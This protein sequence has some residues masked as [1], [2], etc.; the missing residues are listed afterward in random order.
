MTQEALEAEPTT[1]TP[2]QP[3]TGRK[4][5]QAPDVFAP[6]LFV[7][8]SESLAAV[9]VE[10]AMPGTGRKLQQ[11]GMEAAIGPVLPVVPAAELVT[12]P[13]GGATPV[14]GRKL[15]QVRCLALQCT[16]I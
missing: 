2:G 5:H 9:P 8:A 15:K 16:G 12:G 6:L 14:T 4:L 3:V 7:P 1:A 10:G 13:V 11:A